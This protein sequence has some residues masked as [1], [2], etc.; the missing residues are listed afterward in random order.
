MGQKKVSI[1]EDACQKAKFPNQILT[2]QV[3]IGAFGPYIPAE[4]GGRL[5]SNLT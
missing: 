3:E 5:R 1:I 4:Y 2:G